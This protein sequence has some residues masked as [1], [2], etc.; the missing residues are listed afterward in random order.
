MST[1]H[2]N[3]LKNDYNKLRTEM[4]DEVDN[5]QIKFQDNLNITIII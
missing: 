1:Y 4:L 5:L 2:H 3:N